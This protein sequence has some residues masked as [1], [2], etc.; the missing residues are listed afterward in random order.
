MSISIHSDCKLIL[1]ADG[2]T[3][4]FPQKNSGF[5]SQKLG[6]EL[7]S[8]SSLIIGKLPLHPVAFTIADFQINCNGHLLN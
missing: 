3:I 7:E 1:Y 6:K 4:M 2:S 8:C 5:I